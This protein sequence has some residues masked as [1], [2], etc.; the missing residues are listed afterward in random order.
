[1]SIYGMMRTSISGMAAQAQRLTAVS[2]NIAN[3]D[4][5]GYKRSSVEFTS[6]VLPDGSSSAS[7][8]ESGSV[9]RICAGT[10]PAGHVALYIFGDRSCN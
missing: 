8:Y 9:C 4:T 3:A 7:L 6:L 5:T 10:S 1:M 2:D